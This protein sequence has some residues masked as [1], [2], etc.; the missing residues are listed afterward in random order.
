MNIT[1]R[2]NCVLYANKG[3]FTLGD[4]RVVVPMVVKGNCLGLAKLREA[5]TLQ[6]NTQQIVG[7]HC[8]KINNPSVFLLEPIMH[9]DTQGF[10]VPH[11]IIS[12]KG[13]HYCQL[14][15]PTDEPITL[16]A[17]TLIGQL[18]PVSDILS[19]AQDNDPVLFDRRRAK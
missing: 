6:P 4:A 17:G 15:N 14:W 7:L 9:E 5:V 13:W 19:I 3:L 1:T 16:R 10:C 18:A 2:Y 11:L 12:T 8:P